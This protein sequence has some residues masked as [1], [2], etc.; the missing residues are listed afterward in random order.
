MEANNFV[1]A[2]DK[3][4]DKA[5][6]KESKKKTKTVRKNKLPVVLEPEEAEKLIKQPNRRCNTGLRNKTIM[7]LMLHCG[8]RLSEITNLKPGNINLSKGKS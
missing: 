1:R 3:A 4:L 8:L 2:V 5:I 6:I 7:S